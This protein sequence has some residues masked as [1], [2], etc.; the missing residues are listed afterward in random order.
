MAT[1]WLDFAELL[2]SLDPN[3]WC[4]LYFQAEMGKAEAIEL[5]VDI[6]DRVVQT[7]VGLLP[8]YALSL[9]QNTALER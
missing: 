8:L 6:A 3:R 9:R 5:G 2:S 4:D 1:S 7:F